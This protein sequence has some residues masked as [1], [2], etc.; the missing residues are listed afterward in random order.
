MIDG[1]ATNDR[2]KDLDLDVAF[3]RRFAI[4]IDVPLGYLAACWTKT[5]LRNQDSSTEG[6]V[7]VGHYHVSAYFGGSFLLAPRA[8]RG[9]NAAN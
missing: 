8:V 9:A 7:K 1:P 5:C 3:Y 4:S 2:N 6:R